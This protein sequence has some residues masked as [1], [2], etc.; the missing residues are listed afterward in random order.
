MSRLSLSST[1]IR[2]ALMTLSVLVLALAGS[3]GDTW[4]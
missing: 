3:A 1:R 4:S 2:A